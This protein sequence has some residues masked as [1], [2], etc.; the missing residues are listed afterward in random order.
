MENWPEGIVDYIFEVGWWRVSDW[1]RDSVFSSLS[2]QVIYICI[3][4]LD[5]LPKKPAA[6]IL[7][8][9]D[10]EVSCLRTDCAYPLNTKCLS[11]ISAI[12]IFLIIGFIYLPELYIFSSELY[13]YLQSKWDCGPLLNFGPVSLIL[14]RT[15][16]TLTVVWYCWDV[17]KWLT[18][19]HISASTAVTMQAPPEIHRLPAQN[20]LTLLW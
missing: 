13:D 11:L 2:P 4:T 7:Y 20:K 3:I 16:T 8:P 15:W 6:N 5:L 18:G 9:A 1:S 17:F 12:Y 19:W 10:L 14:A